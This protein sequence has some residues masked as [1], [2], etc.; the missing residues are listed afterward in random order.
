MQ[1]VI[2]KQKN[3]ATDLPERD[4]FLLYM[5][6]LLDQHDLICKIVIR[7]FSKLTFLFK[8]QTNKCDQRAPLCPEYAADLAVQPLGRMRLIKLIQLAYRAK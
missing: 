1:W 2:I 4:F 5:Y 8:P 7:R 6:L 3:H